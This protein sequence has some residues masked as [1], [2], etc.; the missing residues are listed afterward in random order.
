MS[1]PNALTKGFNLLFLF[2]ILKGC[3]SP[4]CHSMRISIQ[5]ELSW[6]FSRPPAVSLEHLYLSCTSRNWWSLVVED[7][8]TPTHLPHSLPVLESW[9]SWLPHLGELSLAVLRKICW[10]LVSCSEGNVL[11]PVGYGA[12]KMRRAQNQQCLLASRLIWL[13]GKYFAMLVNIL[14]MLF[15]VIMVT[16]ESALVTR[17]YTMN[18]A[19]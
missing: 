19:S 17:L 9:M 5:A 15:R 2:S 11:L 8:S 7:T 13:S 4:F 18:T 12:V 6:I 1:L 14:P 3:I 16:A 10:A